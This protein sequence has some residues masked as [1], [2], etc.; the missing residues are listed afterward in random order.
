MR[1]LLTAEG[2]VGHTEEGE[3]IGPKNVEDIPILGEAKPGIRLVRWKL[4]ENTASD[5]CG[6]ACN[7][8]ELR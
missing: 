7:G 2:F 4:L 1:K 6:V 8:A 5:G 3:A